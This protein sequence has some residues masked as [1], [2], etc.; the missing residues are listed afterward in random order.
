[1]G[2]ATNGKQPD[3]VSSSTQDSEGRTRHPPHRPLPNY[4]N[5]GFLAAGA[6][7][8]PPKPLQPNPTA[9]VRIKV[10]YVGRPGKTNSV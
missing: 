10:S 4:G 5:D 9:S 6:T 3:T 7:A 1:M 2:L 8:S